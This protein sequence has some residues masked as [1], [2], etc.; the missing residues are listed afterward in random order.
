M[1]CLTGERRKRKKR[2]EKWIIN[3]RMNIFERFFLLLKNMNANRSSF[4]SLLSFF[5][6]SLFFLSS[7]SLSSFFLGSIFFSRVNRMT[8]RW[9][10]CFPSSLFSLSSPLSLSLSLSWG[11]KNE[12]NREKEGSI[13]CSI[14]WN[15]TEERREEKRWKEKIDRDENYDDNS[16]G[17]ADEELSFSFFL[18]FLFFFLSSFSL[19]LSLFLFSFSFFLLLPQ[20]KFQDTK[21]MHACMYVTWEGKEREDKED[22]ERERRWIKKEREKARRE[23]LVS[24]FLL[25]LSLSLLSRMTQNVLSS[26]S[27]LLHDHHPFTIYDTIFW[28]GERKKEKEIEREREKEKERKNLSSNLFQFE[29]KC[30]KIWVFFFLCLLY[31]FSL[32]LSLFLWFEMLFPS[33]IQ[34]GPEWEFSFCFRRKL[35]SV[36]EKSRK[37]ER[38]GRGRKWEKRKRKKREVQTWL[39]L[40]QKPPS[41]NRL[42]FQPTDLSFFFF[43]L[44][45]SLSCL[46][47]LFVLIFPMNFYKEREREEGR[48]TEKRRERKREKEEPAGKKTCP[49]GQVSKVP[50][51]T[52][53]NSFSPLC[54]FSDFSL[55]S[56]FLSFYFSLTF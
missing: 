24:C 33:S 18:S 12:E 22:K 5:S 3:W 37:K 40:V 46:R 32:S 11:R 10:V 31:F 17:W 25:S 2:R 34:T 29:L 21:S 47:L 55:S 28:G 39:K 26:F 38:R 51:F 52:W 41:S 43:L 42:I 16:N 19:F 8:R 27:Y 23:E 45:L 1:N 14:V 20:G 4:P 6:F 44:S 36:L 35:T 15:G 53:T 56:F 50:T 54:P 48:E 9:F 30:K 13:F 7:L 49:L